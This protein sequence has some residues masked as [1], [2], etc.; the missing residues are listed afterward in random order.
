MDL[1]E[2]FHVPWLERSYGALFL[3]CFVCGSVGNS[4]SL[5]YFTARGR[6]SCALIYRFITC[7]DIV[8][9]LLMLPMCVSYFSYRHS[10]FFSNSVF[11]D[12]WGVTWNIAA[13]YSVFLVAV[14]SISRTLSLFFPFMRVKTRTVAVVMCCYLALLVLQGTVPFWKGKRYQYY[15]EYVQCFSLLGELFAYKSAGFI[16][17]YVIFIQIEYTAPLIPILVSCGMS[18]QVIKNMH[19]QTHEKS[20]A[21][22]RKEATWTI[23]LFTLLYA[24]FNVP[25]ALYEMLGAVDLYTENRF[26]FFS[27]DLGHRYF[28]NM[29]SVLSIGLNAAANPALYFWR[30]RGMRPSTKSRFSTIALKLSRRSEGQE[31]LN[32]CCSARILSKVIA[33]SRRTDLSSGDI[34]LRTERRER[35]IS[36]WETK[37]RDDCKTAAKWQSDFEKCVDLLQALR[38]NS[39]LRHRAGL[40]SNFVADRWQILDYI[41]NSRKNLLDEIER[42]KQEKQNIYD[43]YQEYFNLAVDQE[44]EIHYLEE[45]LERTKRQINDQELELHY[46]KEERDVAYKDIHDLEDELADSRMMIHDLRNR[47]LTVLTTGKDGKKVNVAN[48][49]RLTKELEKFQHLDE[50]LALLQEDFLLMEQ[51][52]LAEQKRKK[53]F[54]EQAVIEEKKAREISHQL[55]MIMTNELTP[56]NFKEKVMKQD[57]AALA[58]LPRL[59]GSQ[60]NA[61]LTLFVAAG[62]LPEDKVPKSSEIFTLEELQKSGQYT[63]DQVAG[64]LTGKVSFYADTGTSE[65]EKVPAPQFTSLAPGLVFTN[66]PAGNQVQSDLPNS[67]PPPTSQTAPTAHP[68]A[69]APPNAPPPPTPPA[70]R[71][72]NAPPPPPAPLPPAAPPAP[73]P[74]NAPPPPPAP[75]PPAAPPAPRPPNAPSI[76]PTAPPKAPPRNA[77]PPPPPPPPAPPVLDSRLMAGKEGSGN[78]DNS[79]P[80]AFV[81]RGRLEDLKNRKGRKARNNTVVKKKTLTFGPTKPLK[82]FNWAKLPDAKA[83]NSIWK[84]VD[85]IEMVTML[86]LDEIDDLFQ[87]KKSV[88][89][90]LGFENIFCFFVSS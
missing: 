28:R 84:D 16:I 56:A 65:S 12:L 88:K 71:P 59:S 14:L 63:T 68:M 33:S 69:P 47:P 36:I 6:G 22:R 1:D 5:L 46:V 11:C 4:L 25:A 27:W 20:L 17:F 72:P 60:L 2:E 64:L 13:R 58:D 48:T 57:P 76:G 86:N 43:D 26:D 67:F 8:T 44:E 35:R 45:E 9:S 83:A 62:A 24:V 78:H 31:T 23:I 55:Y 81:P 19:V 90:S 40:L 50:E 32:C 66:R 73:R 54:E 49:D 21:A 70:P 61:L 29:I 52:W 51:K 3:L 75:L 18:I 42:L 39:S 85:E 30:M 79:A 77:P 82:V 38:Q 53:Y 89:V 41:N 10:L 80:G 15:P 7:N 74:P 34:E 37:V 87:S